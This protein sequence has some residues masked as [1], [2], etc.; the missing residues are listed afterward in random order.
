[1]IELKELVDIVT[2]NKVKSI[3]IIGNPSDKES[4]LMQYYD[5]IVENQVNSD[6]EA[7]EKLY[8]N[9]SPKNAFYKLKHQLRD[10]LYNTLFFIDIKQN[11]YSDIKKAEIKCQK[12]L[13]LYNLLKLKGGTRNAVKIAKKGL[14]IALDYELTQEV[15]FLSEKLRSHYASL[16]GDRKSFNHYNN[17]LLEYQKIYLAETD[18]K[19]KYLDLM[20]FYVNSR[21]TKLYV[22]QQAQQY[23]EEVN[24]LDIPRE[25]ADFFYYKT[26][27]EIIFHMSVNDY[28]KTLGVCSM[29]LEKIY[30]FK[31]LNTK[32]KIIISLQYIACCIQLKLYEDGKKEIIEC[33]EIVDEG[34]HTWF[35]LQELYL[36]LCLHTQNYAEA[37]STYQLATGHKKFQNLFTNAQEVW[38]I[39]EAWLY[40]LIKAGKVSTL[41]GN[42]YK[43][44]RIGRFIN[45]VPTFSKDKRGLNVPILIA[46]IVL[47][48]QDCRYDQLIDRMEAIAKYKHRYLDKDENY[49]SNIF[50]RMLLE[51]S[52]ASFK[53]EKTLRH[54]SKYLSMLGEIPLEIS[55]QRHDLE[56][57]PYEDIWG[58]VVEQLAV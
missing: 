48:Q 13:M 58:I 6:E 56:I 34:L 26:M 8:G 54:T 10:R 51:A 38:K 9:S 16:L 57:L 24:K 32:A 44:F 11:K 4:K 39:Y 5:L 3:E 46:Q 2:R 22:K 42:V 18:A 49:R 33:L 7:F 19:G 37:W 41:N 27:L 20:S 50:I 53:R 1:M 30:S 40:F 47:L 23:L 17:I 14:K 15:I 25:T 31:Y 52:K 55:N 45:E 29:A 12:S 28:S 35:K 21:A 36:T 43:K